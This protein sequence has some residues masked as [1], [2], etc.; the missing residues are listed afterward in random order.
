[1]NATSEKLPEKVPAPKSG[2]TTRSP[3]EIQTETQ[4]FLGICLPPGL[5]AKL[6]Q[7]GHPV[8]LYC[9]VFAGT[10]QIQSHT[11]RASRRAEQEMAKQRLQRLDDH[12]TYL[13]MI[14]HL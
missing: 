2:G 5:H 13:L 3:K 4:L 14:S 7:N 8:D 11:E 1:M 9:D 6:K 10:D 12:I